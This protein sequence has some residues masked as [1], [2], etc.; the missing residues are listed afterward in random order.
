[1]MSTAG[2]RV[3]L[4]IVQALMATVSWIFLM[5]AICGLSLDFGTMRNTAWAQKW[6]WETGDESTY[7][8]LLGICSNFKLHCRR[9]H[10]CECAAYGEIEWRA[11][12]PLFY[13]GMSKG[14]IPQII[15]MILAFIAG[16]SYFFC[17]WHLI[18]FPFSEIFERVERYQVISGSSA[19]LCLMIT[20]ATFAGLIEL[21]EGCGYGP[22]FGSAVTSWVFISLSL[23][24]A[25]FIINHKDELD[26]HSGNPHSQASM[27]R[28]AS[29]PPREY[30]PGKPTPS[31]VSR[32]SAPSTPS[33]LESS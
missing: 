16:V 13:G 19:W 20:W 11:P 28:A 32:I 22:G 29:N 9:K 3:D 14:Y 2:E 26:F 4:R 30:T 5:V 18:R 15:F 33:Q 17:S 31:R 7:A 10:M 27:Q 25:V 23:P 6:T 12:R 24:L 21:K 8:N 1:M